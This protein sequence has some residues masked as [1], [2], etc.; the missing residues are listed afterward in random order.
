MHFASQLC[1]QLPQSIWKFYISCLLLGIQWWKVPTC[2]SGF[3]LSNWTL[4]T[5]SRPFKNKRARPSVALAVFC[6]SSSGSPGWVLFKLCQHQTTAHLAR[7]QHLNN[8]SYVS[9]GCVHCSRRHYVNIH[10]PQ[11]CPFRRLDQPDE[12]K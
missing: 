6:F 1:M 9:G 8:P 10:S 3:S 12:T 4:T 7:K 11:L 2:H 5:A